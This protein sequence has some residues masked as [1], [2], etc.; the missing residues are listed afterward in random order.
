M[1]RVEEG[2]EAVGVASIIRHRVDRGRGGG[3]EAVHGVLLTESFI[4]CEH[5]L[6]LEILLLV[7]GHPITGKVKVILATILQ[8]TF[9]LSSRMEVFSVL[10]TLFLSTGQLQ[11]G[12]FIRS[13]QLVLL[14]ILLDFLGHPSPRQV[15]A[16]LP[17]SL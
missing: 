14:E 8:H 15:A 2:R 11:T 3:S 17:A 16:L 6:L 13:G 1:G 9:Q 7:L 12:S 5:L 4:S 10:D